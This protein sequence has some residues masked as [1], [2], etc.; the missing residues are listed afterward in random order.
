MAQRVRRDV[1]GD[2]ARLRSH[3]P[4]LQRCGSRLSSSTPT[5]RLCPTRP[6]RCSVCFRAPRPFTGP[7]GEHMSFYDDR[8]KVSEAADRIAE[9]FRRSLR[10]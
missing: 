3:H 5:K 7:S 6:K 8:S 9:H 1:L 4:T 2:V 10:A